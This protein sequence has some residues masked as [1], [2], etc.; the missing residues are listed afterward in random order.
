M[1]KSTLT[2]WVE[3]EAVRSDYSWDRGALR[4]AQVGR[5]LK[6]RPRT[7]RPDTHLIRIDVDVPHTAFEHR[8]KI[9]LSD[10]SAA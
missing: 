3:A 7:A 8:V 6:K 10:A 1:N 5:L 4:Y 9:D 2:V